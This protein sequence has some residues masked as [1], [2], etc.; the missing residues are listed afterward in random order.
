MP[1][2]TKEYLNEKLKENRKKTMEFSTQMKRIKIE[3]LKLSIVRTELYDRLM[4]IGS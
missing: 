2:V 1:K 3:L 4:E